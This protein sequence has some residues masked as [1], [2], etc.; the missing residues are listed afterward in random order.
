[1]SVK[2]S[3]QLLNKLLDL[4]QDGKASAIGPHNWDN[5]P[6]PPL[7]LTEQLKDIRKLSSHFLE[8][9]DDGVWY[10]LKGS[11]GN[12][13]SALVGDLVRKLKAN[14]WLENEYKFKYQEEQ[15]PYVFDLSKNGEKWTSLRIV[16][17]A[18]VSTDPFDPE[19]TLASQLVELLE[20]AYL[21]G[22]SLVI[23]ANRGVIEQLP[24]VK[25]IND[26]QWYHSRKFIKNL[27]CD[28]NKKA[29]YKN[30]EVREI[31]LDQEKITGSIDSPLSELIDELV[32]LDE[33][34]E[35][36]NCINN[37]LC[38]FFA[39][40]NILLNL[41]YKK[42]FIEILTQVEIYRGQPIVFREAASLLSIVLSGSSDDYIH[43][44]STTPCNWVHTS[45]DSGNYQLL[46]S[47]KI[48]MI[49]FGG[50]AMSGLDD[51]KF[52]RDD[53]LQTI[54]EVVSI[55]SKEQNIWTNLNPD[56]P[57]ISGCKDLRDNLSSLDP[58][59]SKLNINDVEKCNFEN[60]DYIE[61]LR[62]EIEYWN[63]EL[64]CISAW[65]KIS[66]M[67]EDIDD[68]K[69]NEVLERLSSAFMIRHLGFITHPDYSIKMNFEEQLSEFIQL[70]ETIPKIHSADGDYSNEELS[71]YDKAID[72]I[73]NA[74]D[75]ISSG[76]SGKTKLSEGLEADNSFLNSLM[77]VNLI[78]DSKPKLNLLIEFGRS[79]KV[80]SQLTGKLYCWLSITA[81]DTHSTLLV[82][83]IPKNIIA[84][85]RVTRRQAISKSSYL[86]NE[87]VELYVND[88]TS[89]VN[90]Y[91]LHKH[92][93]TGKLIVRKEAK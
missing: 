90:S 46:I 10:I 40:R 76:R 20:E 3:N 77:K 31:E 75:R 30:I 32:N 9:H 44:Q 65:K 89:D 84:G 27:K 83:F 68:S 93:N 72:L 36:Q 88:N 67:L 73:K 66:L 12:G 16:Q 51:D 47:R 33:W 7:V 60:E 81:H 85:I 17:D 80:Q 13:K 5:D 39:N 28:D 69:P 23:C 61:L 50:K 53:Q 56:A 55:I 41:N 8:N 42:R 48:Y 25:G 4:Q 11:P 87:D 29:V 64:E 21:K 78:E 52:I 71:I 34:S 24:D 18:S 15:L 19:T 37:N 38:P 1:M 54:S 14:G 22:Q 91:C 63:L 35:C 92:K 49:L 6:F 26:K 59:I 2:I 58:L 57:A 74:L 86:T 43:N 45:V 82:D 79:L 70:L 62:S